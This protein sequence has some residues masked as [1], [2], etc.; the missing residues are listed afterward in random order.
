MLDWRI[1]LGRFLNT[2]SSVYKKIIKAIENEKLLDFSIS[3]WFSNKTSDK[4][5]E[6]LSDNLNIKSLKV[7]DD[8]YIFS[9]SKNYSLISDDLEKFRDQLANNKSLVLSSPLISMVSEPDEISDLIIKNQKPSNPVFHLPSNNEQDRII[10]TLDNND[11]VVVKGPPGTGKTHTIANLICHYLNEGKKVLVTSAK[12]SSLSVIRS[13]LP[14]N[15][16]NLI[17]SPFKD[18]DA[19]TINKTIENLLLRLQTF[20]LDEINKEVLDLENSKNT[21][22]KKN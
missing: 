7:E 15:L 12:D 16:R 20:N 1:E 9:R 19:S 17:V 5:Q 11:V 22:C 2:D 18:G 6:I 21:L 10:S 8:W 13:M 3:S 14:Q 4:L